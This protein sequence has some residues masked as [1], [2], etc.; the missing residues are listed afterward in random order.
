MP[1][2]RYVCLSDMHLG[3]DNSVL[4]AIKP[5]SI[6]T[7]TSQPSAVL[8]QLVVCL[9]ELIAQNEST[10]KPTLV[11]NGDILEMALSDTNRAAMVFERFIELIF[12]QEGEALFNKNILYIPG[13]H[14][15][16]IWESA[17]ET[18]Y[19]S[20]IARIRP[21]AELPAP[22]HTTKMLAPDLVRE[23]FLTNLLQRYSHLQDATVNV[24]YPNYALVNNDGQ[25]CI[26]FSH[27]HYIES[28]YS[29]MSTLNT[30][31][32]PHRN[33][34]EVVWEL[35]AENFAWIDFF[36]STMGRSGDVGQDIGVFYAKLQDR[37]QVEKLIAN[38]VTSWLKQS[39]QP[40]WIQGIEAK[41]LE[42]L[43]DFV[44]SRI[45][46]LE[47]QRTSQILSPDA[48]RGLQWYLEGPLLEQARRENKQSIPADTTLLFG[49]T[50]KPFQQ[51]MNFA[52]YP[53]PLKVY[54]SGGWV[55]D[56]VERSPIHGAAVILID[57]TLQAVTLR[58]YNQATHVEEYAVHVEEAT[59][60]G[61]MSSAFYDRIT[62]LVNH[63][64]DPWKA[65][66]EAAAEA[67]RLHAQVLQS[68]ID[69][70]V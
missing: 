40:E 19:V 9:R 16:H 65:F 51:E 58:M 33:R 57:E 52:G 41:G 43:L 39:H 24:V 30:M 34:P 32:F 36:W 44:Y 21:G 4:T 56:T 54:N 60:P 6:E 7:D 46:P 35:E 37:Q 42:W 3:A 69:L 14:D 20:F 29:L 18:Q 66:S 53:A 31:V 50:H 26:I 11:L 64:S 15:H 23:Y 68:K 55:V 49:H 45:S 28:I 47:K 10:Q 63:A 13:N 67:V 1:D 62:A 17:R 8:H 70:Q 48:Q 2:I 25:K 27:G 12:P 5:N 22:W 38:F 59:H 61:T